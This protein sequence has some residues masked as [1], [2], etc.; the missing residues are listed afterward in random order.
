MSALLAAV[1]LFAALAPAPLRLGTRGRSGR[2]GWLPGGTATRLAAVSG[3]WGRRHGRDDA[4]P[5]AL[6][7]TARALRSGASVLTALDTV[8]TEIPETGWRQVVGRVSGGLGLAEALDGW[9]QDLPER[10]TAAALL[11]LGHQSGAAMAA[12]LDRAATSMRQRRALGDEIRALTS[13]TR[14]SGMVVAAAPAGFA[15]VIVVADPGA[16]GALVATPFGLLSL[17]AGVAL[18]GLG[19]WWMARLSRGVV[20]WA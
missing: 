12:S 8:A 10:Q 17:V 18:E 14:T 15:A 13:Q 9:V 4:I 19:V 3:L 5:Q 20:R 7:L 1:L 6:E 11:V 16:L 2:L